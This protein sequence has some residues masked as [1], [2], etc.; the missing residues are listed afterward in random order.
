[1]SRGLR[2]LGE[3]GL[4][5]PGNGTGYDGAHGAVVIFEGQ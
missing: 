3:G 1:M 5:T 4:G 2:N